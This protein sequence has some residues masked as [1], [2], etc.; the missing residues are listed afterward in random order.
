M[1]LVLA[2]VEQKVTELSVCSQSFSN[3]Q[4]AKRAPSVPRK[5]VIP[6]GRYSALLFPTSAYRADVVVVIAID[7]EVIRIDSG[8]SRLHVSDK[9]QYLPA[10]ADRSALHPNDV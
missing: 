7:V 3:P 10:I 9:A 8:M 4:N 1:L 5:N 2:S 6:D